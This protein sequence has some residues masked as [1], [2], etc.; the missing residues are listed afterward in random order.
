MTSLVDKGKQCPVCGKMVFG[1]VHDMLGNQM[2]LE[3]LAYLIPSLNI[4]AWMKAPPVIISTTE[5]Q[6]KEDVTLT[7]PDYNAD[8]D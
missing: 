4:S 1:L 3:C 7:G 6:W 2:C 8:S 5:G